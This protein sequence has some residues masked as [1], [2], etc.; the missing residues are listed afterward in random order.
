MELAKSKV[1][2]KFNDMCLK[3]KTDSDQTDP[4]KLQFM[5]IFYVKHDV[6]EYRS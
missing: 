3:Y 6:S 4:Q 1:K 2:T 5:L